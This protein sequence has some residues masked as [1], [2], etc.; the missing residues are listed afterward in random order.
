MFVGFF[1]TVFVMVFSVFFVAGISNPDFSFECHPDL[2]H[3]Q[4]DLVIDDVV[5]DVGSF[6]LDRG[7]FEVDRGLF[8]VVV[9]VVVSLLSS[10]IVVEGYHDVIDHVHNNKTKYFRL[11]LSYEVSSE[12]PKTDLRDA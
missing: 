3:N 11:R 6:D 5:G 4:P 1:M 2:S 8:V 7:S 10:L 9:V 12:I